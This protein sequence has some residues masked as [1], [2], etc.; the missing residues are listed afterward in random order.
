VLEVAAVR[1]AW[2]YKP[3]VIEHDGEAERVP[4]DRDEHI[5]RV[6][7]LAAA[8]ELPACRSAATEEN[9]TTT[10]RDWL[11]WLQVSRTHRP[12]SEPIRTLTSRLRSERSVDF[13]RRGSSSD[14]FCPGEACAQAGD[15]TKTASKS[16]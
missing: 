7:A 6:V 16:V 9:V 12:I 5:Q 3:I 14:R 15:S 11:S 8:A 1:E 13:G 4:P 2:V 10:A